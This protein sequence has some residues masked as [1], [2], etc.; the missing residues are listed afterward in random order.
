MMRK[1][2]TVYVLGFASIFLAPVW[3]AGLVAG[4]YALRIAAA[5]QHS[6]RWND[7]RVRR[8]VRGGRV[9]SWIGCGLS[10][11]VLAVALYSVIVTAII[12]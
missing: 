4:W 8:D 5:E 1:A 7:E 11:L 2:T 12:L 9:L 10:A 3:G 6:D